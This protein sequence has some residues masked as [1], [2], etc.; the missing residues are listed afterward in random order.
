M[1][2][3]YD[4]PHSERPPSLD[5]AQFVVH[6]REHQRDLDLA[7]LDTSTTSPSNR[8]SSSTQAL[9]ALLVVLLLIAGMLF[10]FH[11]L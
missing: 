11:L 5:D 2:E 10:W 8:L 7:R 4:M 6:E 1:K 3:I 9:I